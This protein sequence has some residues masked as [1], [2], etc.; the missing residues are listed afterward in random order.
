MSHHCHAVGCEVEIPT[1]LHMCLMHWK[2]VPRA[3]Q[4]LIWKHYRKDQEI[5]KQPSL[6][7]ICTAFVSIACVALR[8][9]KE[10]PK[11]KGL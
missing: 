6:E 4:D 7:Y 10:L 8:E 9:G 5:D 1:K 3:V 2:M 11:M